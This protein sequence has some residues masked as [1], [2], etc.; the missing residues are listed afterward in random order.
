MK[1]SPGVADRSYGIHVAKLAGLPE[2][3]IARAS[4]VLKTLEDDG[5]DNRR[6]LAEDLPLFRAAPPAAAAPAKA[7]AVESMLRDINPDELT[8]RQALAML[9]DLKS[10]LKARN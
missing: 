6:G 2:A 4:E 3:V 9:Y 8:A 1:C 5:G 10:N 7:S